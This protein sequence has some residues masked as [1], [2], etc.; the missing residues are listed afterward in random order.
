MLDRRLYARGTGIKRF[1][2]ELV[3]VS[4]TKKSENDDSHM[5]C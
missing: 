3:I 5:G 1:Q 4:A 2:S